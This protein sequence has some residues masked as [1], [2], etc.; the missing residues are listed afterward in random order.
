MDYYC[1][2]CDNFIKPKS[3]KNHFKSK[4]HKEFNKCKHIELTIENPNM[5]NRDE[6]FYAYIIEHN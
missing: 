5:N 2:I 6:I 3:K 1:E 4:I